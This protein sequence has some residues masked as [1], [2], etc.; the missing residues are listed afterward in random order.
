MRKIARGVLVFLATFHVFAQT[1]GRGS[2][3]VMN[4]DYARFRNDASSGYL[5]IYYLFYCGQLSFQLD[6][7][8]LKGAIVLN[9]EVINQQTGERVVKE[10]VVL[11]VVIQDT[12]VATRTK[13]VVRQSGHLIANGKYVLHVVAYDSAKP[14]MSDSISLSVDIIEFAGTPAMSDLE[15]CSSIRA[16]QDKTDPF[17]K[18]AHEVV[19]NP[20]LVFGRDYPVIYVY[21]EFYDVDT[22]KVY[23]LEYAVVDDAGNVV[24]KT[25]RSRRYAVP[26]AVDVGTMNALSFRS[27]RYSLR[28][29]MK[30]AQSGKSTEV[31]KRFYVNNPSIAQGPAK[32][33]SQPLESGI[34][35]LTPE[36]T[37]RE[38]LQVKY[39][40]TEPEM[41]L[42]DQLKDPQGKRKFLHDFWKRIEAGS[43]DQPP[44]RRADYLRNVAI[45][46]ERFSYLS[47]QGWQTD[48]GRV[49]AVYGPPDQIERHPSEGETKPFEIWN[50]YQIENGVQFIFVDWTGFGD[51]QLVHSTKRGEVKDEEWGRYLH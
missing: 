19:A 15:L 14:V 1:Q 3:F 21:T 10:R 29:N 18:N 6:G 50:Y 48:R 32:S 4:L 47:K 43:E 7:A 51:Y 30:D 12:S 8:R 2:S 42:F 5:E 45:A 11:P 31:E 9:T 28:L 34:E 49:L 33:L 37:D 27:G 25:N 23:A 17:Y 24:K 22:S 39:L 44:R 35:A 41:Y 36:E 40:A 13:S 38:F 20:T 46:N 26:N 16:S